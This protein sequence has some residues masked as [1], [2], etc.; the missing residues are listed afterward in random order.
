MPRL[1][2]CACRS[3]IDGGDVSTGF[4]RWTVTRFSLCREARRLMVTET[5]IS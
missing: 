4:L 2:S 5:F 1:T 3:P